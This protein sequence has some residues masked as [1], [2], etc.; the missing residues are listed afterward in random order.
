MRVEVGTSWVVPGVKNPGMVRYSAFSRSC[1]HGSQSLDPALWRAGR[2]FSRAPS[3]IWRWNAKDA[4]RNTT[5]AFTMP[6]LIIF[7]I[8][9]ASP[10]F[11]DRALRRSFYSSSIYG[12]YRP[13]ASTQV[14]GQILCL[15]LHHQQLRRLW[16]R[17]IFDKALIARRRICRQ[18]C[19]AG[20][21][22]PSVSHLARERQHDLPGE[23]RTARARPT[24]G[25]HESPRTTKLY[26]RTKDEIT[27]EL[28]GADPAVTFDPKLRC[29]GERNARLR[30]EPLYFRR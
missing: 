30:S 16:I 17:C 12:L 14:D 26:D 7:D 18:S 5:R 28:G 29:R 20:F 8:W 19:L 3:P 27:L 15:R 1:S 22:S 9:R 6:P 21:Q 2:D 10:G 23:R 24:N 11:C 25:R 4:Y 13:H